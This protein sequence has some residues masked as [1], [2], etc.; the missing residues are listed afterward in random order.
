ME[1]PV[2]PTGR[3]IQA[4]GWVKIGFRQKSRYISK[5]AQDMDTVT[6]ES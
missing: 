5:T 1:S 3:Q 2:N 6:T 4:M